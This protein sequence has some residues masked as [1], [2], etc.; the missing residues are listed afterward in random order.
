MSATVITLVVALAAAPANE[1]PAKGADKAEK[2]ADRGAVERLADKP[3]AVKAPDKS[4]AAEKAAGPK[5]PAAP[6]ETFEEG[7]GYYYGD[8]FAQAAAAMY[9]YLSTNEQTVENYEWAEFFLGA[10]FARMGLEHGAAEYLFNVAKNRTRPEIL[11]DALAELEALMARPHDEGLLDQA[12][13]ADTEFGYLPP[14]NADFVNWMQ[15]LQDLRA[16]RLSWAEKSFRRIRAESPWAPRSLYALGVERLDRGLD[17]EAAGYFRRALV[18]VSADRDVRNQSRLALARMLYEA[19]RWAAARKI[20]DQVEVPELS[21]AEASLYLEKAWTSYF[22]RDFRKTMGILYALEA[23]SYR[24]YFAPEVFLLRALVYKNLCHY[25]P[26]KREIRRFRLRYGKTLENV[27]ARIDLREDDVLRAAALERGK[28]A[29]LAELRR[30]LTRERDAID[31]VGGPWIETGLDEHLR[32]IYGLKAKQIDLELEAELTAETRKVAE[33]LV[34]FEE[35]MYLL[36]Y[37]I[38]L[39]IYRRL[40]KEEARRPTEADDLTIPSSGPRTYFP[41]VDEFW[42]DELPRYDFFVE[43]RCFDEGQGEE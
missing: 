9:D 29:R 17:A 18:H 26:A 6:P 33:E 30:K 36:D 7:L 12:L 19:E 2:T 41:F 22:L 13:L 5:R 10:S 31:D 32:E 42:N 15:G 4:A 14:A 21:T 28:L 35:Q 27:R 1:A 43:N 39:S 25:I 16:G 34:E 23:P 38:G 24:S 20:Y 40:K 3:A 11:P 8:D 37:E